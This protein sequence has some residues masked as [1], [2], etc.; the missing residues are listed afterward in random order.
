MHVF[1]IKGRI[2]ITV[3]LAFFYSLHFITVVYDFSKIIMYTQ[4][5][6]GNKQF[7]Q[8]IASIVINLS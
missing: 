5:C 4:E 7:N 8:Y 3:I 6:L 2:C 1:S